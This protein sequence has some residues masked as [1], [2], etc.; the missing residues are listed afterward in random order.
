M[1]SG[2]HTGAF[3]SGDNNGR[4]HPY[5]AEGQSNTAATSDSC[6]P[7]FA[8]WAGGSAH[9]V[10]HSTMMTQ[11]E[12]VSDASS[13]P[14]SSWNITTPDVFNSDGGVEEES[15]TEDG[16]S[17]TSDG[18]YVHVSPVYLPPRASFSGS[19]TSNA[20][21]TQDLPSSPPG[22]VA[23]DMQHRLGAVAPSNVQFSRAQWGSIC[24][25]GG[26]FTC[27]HQPHHGYNNG[28]C[29]PMRYT[30]VEHAPLS[31]GQTYSD[32]AF[33]SMNAQTCNAPLPYQ[34][35]HGHDQYILAPNINGGNSITPNCHSQGRGY[36]PSDPYV[37]QQQHTHTFEPRPKRH[38]ISDTGF[39]TQ[40]HI[41]WT[42]SLLVQPQPNSVTVT[43]KMEQAQSSPSP[44]PIVPNFARRSIPS[45]LSHRSSLYPQPSTRPNSSTS[46]ALQYSSQVAVP[47]SQ[48]GGSASNRSSQAARL[49][50]L[51]SNAPGSSAAEQGRKG[52][53]QKGRH[54]ADEAKV[55]S[56]QM[57][58]TVACWRCA[59]QRDPV[60]PITTFVWWDRAY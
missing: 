20:S 8:G 44:M 37:Q 40:L 56:S 51:P 27:N 28:F 38:D 34:A 31:A 49:R 5:T 21:F 7:G 17:S 36:G 16:I 23:F 52:G 45:V 12:S 55:K 30:Q 33:T 9:Q 26:S 53:R 4:N 15:D 14:A 39:L 22:S 19:Q 46:A 10:S 41:P 25:D 3:T 1:A 54:L 47:Q 13:S 57:R 35:G 6:Y 48:A 60:C 50:P 32:V 58:K 18:S 43:Q 24:A 2:E 11:V 59:L 29:I 42:G